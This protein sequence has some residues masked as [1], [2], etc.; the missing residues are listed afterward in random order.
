MIVFS[1]FCMSI[2]L[3]LQGRLSSVATYS[4]SLGGHNQ[5]WGQEYTPNRLVDLVSSVNSR[6]ETDPIERLEHNSIV[7][8]DSTQSLN[9]R[10][11]DIFRQDL[12]HQNDYKTARKTEGFIDQLPPA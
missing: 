1:L 4:V 11:M 3:C 9:D 8:T 5:G 7:A 12:H 10:K 2:R 6:Q